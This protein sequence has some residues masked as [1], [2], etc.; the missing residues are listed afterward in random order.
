M[1][2]DPQILNNE[3]AQLAEK[4]FNESDLKDLREVWFKITDNDF[5]TISWK[6]FIRHK[7]KTSSHGFA[8]HPTKQNFH[9]RFFSAMPIKIRLL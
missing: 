3:K 4:K 9:F 5:I 2:Q 8:T 7:M 1:L 6:K